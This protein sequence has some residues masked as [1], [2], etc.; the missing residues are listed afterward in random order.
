MILYNHYIGG[1]RIFMKHQVEIKI[2]DSWSESEIIKLYKAGG[3]WKNS[4]DPSGIKYLI[5]GSFAFVVAVEKT[6]KKTIGMGRLISDGVSDAYIQDT[7]VLPE[8]RRMGIGGMIV[9]TLLDYCL[10]KG[11]LWIG[12]IAEPN[13][14]IFYSTLGFKV[15]EKYVPMKYPTEE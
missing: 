9:K 4:Y 8:Y 5:K 15:M 1:Y 13:Q 10:S 3:W 6:T 2:V 11:I 14:D 12:L 7:V